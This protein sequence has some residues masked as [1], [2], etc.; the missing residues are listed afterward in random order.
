MTHLISKNILIFVINGTL[1]LVHTVSAAKMRT[2]EMS[3]ENV[4]YFYYSKMTTIQM[5]TMTITIKQILQAKQLSL[6]NIKTKLI[7]F[8]QICTENILN[9]IINITKNSIILRY[10]NYVMFSCY[11]CGNQLNIPRRVDKLSIVVKKIFIK[12]F[13]RLVSINCECNL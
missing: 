7:S 9:D 13:L 1:I 5:T 12:A 4:D 6:T 11:I 2:F 8:K 10:N 3:L